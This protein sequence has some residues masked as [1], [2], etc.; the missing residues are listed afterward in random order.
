MARLA[1]L[2]PV[3][4][5]PEQQ[6]I[7]DDIAAGPRGTV[8][9]PQQI[10]LHSPA[11]AEPAQAVGAFCRYGSTLP[12]ALSELAIITV[13]KTWGADYEFWAHAKIAREAG[14]PDDVIEAIRTGGE[15]DFAH[16][17]EHAALVHHAAKQMLERG[18]LPDDDYAALIEAFGK[19]GTVELV[20]IVGYYCLVSLTLNVFEVVTPDGSKPV[21]A[22]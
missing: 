6:R 8:P 9:P 7:H 17:P 18:R 2:A 16:A 4:L 1:P 5:S 19:Q 21:S 13:G 15:P 10:W 14:I 20:G 11:F 22:A 12:L 3:P